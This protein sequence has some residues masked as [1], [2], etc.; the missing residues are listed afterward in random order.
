MAVIA[1]LVGLRPKPVENCRVLELGCAAGANLIPMAE[2]LPDST[3]VGIDMSERQVEVGRKAISDLG[4]NN[5]EL[6]LQAIQDFVAGSEKFDYILCHG[7]FSWVPAEVQERILGI[8]REAL[9]PEGVAYISYNTLPGWHMRGMIRDMML[10]HSRRFSEPQQQI[11][12]ARGLLDFLVTSVPM[13]ENPYGQ[14]LRSE[15]ESLR[16]SPDSYLFHDHLEEHNSPVYFHQFVE[17]ASAQGLRFLAEVPLDSMD[18]RNFA[19]EIGQTLQR[20]SSDMV[21]MEQYMDFLRNRMF[22]QTL[23]CHANHTPNYRLDLETLTPYFLASSLRPSSARPDLSQGVREDYWGAGGVNAWSINSVVKA[24]L[25]VL[26]A[27]WPQSVPFRE[28]CSR[29]Q[30]KLPGGD[31]MTIPLSREEEQQVTQAFLRFYLIGDRLVELRP[32]PLK[33]TTQPGAQPMARPLARWQAQSGWPIVNVRHECVTLDEF[34]RQVLLRLDGKHTRPAVVGELTGL[35]ADGTLT[36][37]QGGVKVI[38]PEQIR[39]ILTQAVDQKIEE[40]G[41]LALVLS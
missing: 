29:A 24:S 14:F 22:R 10:Y 30:A 4:L 27:V 23:L 40:L 36:A 17:R 3:F 20:V 6:R 13:Q 18:S 16:R 11:A 33:L 12:Q 15:L 32:R 2:E 8:C 21:Q 28:L 31:S 1:S 7:V 5:I 9:A 39:Q 19:P 41:R 26:G 38:D 37:Q 34:G 35:V 25:L